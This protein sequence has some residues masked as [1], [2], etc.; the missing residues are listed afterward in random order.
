MAKCSSLV[1]VPG[2]SASASP[3]VTGL[4]AGTAAQA[5]RASSQP[6]TPAPSPAAE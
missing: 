3:S 2:F 6:A 5:P 1:L 4:P